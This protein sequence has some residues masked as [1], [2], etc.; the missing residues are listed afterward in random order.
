MKGT[1]Q[2][3]GQWR[4]WRE[5]ND[6]SEKPKESLREEK[7]R[8]KHGVVFL[9]VAGDEVAVGGDEVGRWEC[10]ADGEDVAFG[11]LCGDDQLRFSKPS[12]FDF[13]MALST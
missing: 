7:E 2:P 11:D 4:R 3:E 1:W 5:A 12:G 9:N 13:G 10:G 6:E 8:T